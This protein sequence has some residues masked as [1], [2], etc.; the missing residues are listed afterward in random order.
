VRA[1]TGALALVRLILRRDRI[2]LPVWVLALVSITYATAQAVV[3]TY[4]TPVEI[5]SYAR[6]LGTSPATIAMAGPPIG[7][8]SISGIVVYETS[9]TVLI[10]TAL[11]A[12]FT[13]VRHTRAEEEVG[14]TELLASTVLGRHA[15]V[16][17]ACAVSAGA[18]LL[19]ALGV[20]GSVLA[21]DMPLSTS[22]A[23]GAAVAGLGL[24]F[25]A[26]AAVAAQVVT[27][28]RTAR[29]VSIAVLGVA[30][31]LRAV[32]DVRESGLSWTSP[33][34]WS[35]QVRIAGDIR[36]WPMLLLAGAASALL[37]W[38]AWLVTRRDVGAGRPG[39]RRDDAR[40]ARG[41]GS[42]F[43]LAWR[44]QRGSVLGWGVGTFLLGLVFGSLSKEMQGMVQDNPTL[45]KVFAATGGDITDSLFAIALLFVGLTVAGFAVSSA[46]RLRGEESS[47]RV[48]VLL[49]GAVSRWRLLL[50]TLGVTLLGSLALVTVGGLGLGLADAAVRSDAGS[51]PRLVGLAWV[52]LPAVLVLAAIAVLLT[53]WLPR[54]SALAWL[55]VVVAFVVGWLGGVLDI[56]GAI[57][58]LSPYEHLPQVPVDDVTATPLVVLT[59]LAAAL[60][61][62]GVEGFR[63]RDLTG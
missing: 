10:G 36:V 18:V 58:T 49:A 46:L 50:G 31:A 7:L 11:M 51:I 39:P 41:L 15:P 34:G 38:A 13:V 42:P 53:G 25:T 8:D 3:G 30:F 60:T 27:H 59:L 40:A 57:R 17:A 2:V 33:I 63:R 54:A 16:A 43:A 9:L 47:G 6:N 44:L 35:Q 37:A 26:I 55:G 19:V 32:G 23:Y 21:V 29:G 20:V 12:I 14:R 52:Q 62:A 48:E 22:W 4:N 1:I 28:A 45:A 56:P 24:V 5:A 61:A